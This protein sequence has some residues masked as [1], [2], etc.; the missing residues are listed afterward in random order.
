MMRQHLFSACVVS[1]LFL[2]VG[3]CDDDP[4]AIQPP[5]TYDFKL[6]DLS[7]NEFQLSKHQ[8]S[9]VI[10]NFFKTTCSHCQAETPDL[11][12]LYETY[13]DDG[14][15]VVGISPEPKD[16]LKS[17]RDAYEITYPVLYDSTGVVSG[18][19]QSSRPTPGLYFV[20]REGIIR[21]SSFGQARTYEEFDAVVKSLL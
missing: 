15:V 1:L 11:V 7:G 3:G 8:G 5:K 18:F 14:L 2:L 10:M 19:Y 13:K 6:S 21:V 16:E 12:K 20:D 4:T 17:F 9:V